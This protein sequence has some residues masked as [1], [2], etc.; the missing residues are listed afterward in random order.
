MYKSSLLFIALHGFHL[1]FRN[2]KKYL[3]ISEMIL[4]YSSVGYG[5][6]T[7][8]LFCYWISSVGG[9]NNLMYEPASITSYWIV[10]LVADHRMPVEW[11]TQEAVIFVLAGC[12]GMCS[13][14]GMRMCYEQGDAILCC[15]FYLD[16]ECVDLCPN[17]TQPDSNFNCRKLIS[18]LRWILPVSLTSIAIFYN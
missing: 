18:I 2:L 1:C 5:Q 15:N 12:S 11:H 4:E 17:T 16:G 8:L 7:E 10:P 6:T 9:P 3:L 13:G 14:A